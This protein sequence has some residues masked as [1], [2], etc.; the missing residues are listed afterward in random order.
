[1]QNWVTTTFSS[2]T[3]E[4]VILTV[5]IDEMT[6]I[7][8]L[9]SEWLLNRLCRAV[10]KRFPDEC[11]RIKRSKATVSTAHVV[12]TVVCHYGGPQS[13]P[14][15]LYLARCHSHSPD[16]D[17]SKAC[18]KWGLN[19][20]WFVFT[21]LWLDRFDNEN[22]FQWKCG[23]ILALISIVR[24][25]NYPLKD[26]YWICSVSRFAQQSRLDVLGVTR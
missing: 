14:P 7:V 16:G 21:I 22:L 25:Q 13:L 26:G 4:T 24:Y 10:H 18:C 23:P 8:L 6:A 5:G 17:G 11:S 1:M 15:S 2:Y 19:P 3:E 9:D 20:S 12:I